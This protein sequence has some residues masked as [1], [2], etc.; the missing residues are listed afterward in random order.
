MAAEGF[1]RKL[2]AILS[3]DAVGYS[4]LM[5]EDEVATLRTL[6]TYKRVIAALIQQHRGRVVGSPGDNILAEFASVVDAVQCAV[7][8]QKEIQARNQELP[9]TRRMQF[10]IGINLGDV[11]ETEDSIYGDG[12]NI[13]ARLESLAE[14]GGICISKTAFDHIETKLP[15]GYEYLGGQTV[16]NIARPVPAYKVMMEPRVTLKAQAQAKPKE[17]ARRRSRF[18]A[19]VSILLLAV[20]AMVVWRFAFPLAGHKLEKAS[21][22]QMAFPL[23]DKP[24]IAVMPFLN[25]SGEQNQDFFCDGLSES[26]ITALSKMP[27]LFVIAQDSTFRYKGKGV[28]TKQVSEELGVQYVLE[29]SVQRAGDR[30]RVTAQLSDALTGQQLWSERYDRSVKDIFDLQDEI[31]MKILTE[32]R[33]KIFTGGETARVVTKETNNLQA[34][35]K[36]LEAAW[37]RN[38]N[39]KE[40]NAVSKRLLEEA[41]RLDPNY[42]SAHIGLSYTLAKEVWLGASESPQETLANAMKEARRAIELDNSSAEAQAAASNIFLLLRQHDK[43]IEVAQQAV[44]LNPN[45]F[46]AMY[47]LATALNFSFR[48]E[49]ALP[50]LRQVI[51]FNP[52]APAAYY[53][54]GV[55]CRETGKYEEGIAAVKKSLQIAPN[56]LFANIILAT[57]YSYAGREAEARAAAAEVMRIDPNFSLIKYAKGIPWK[58]GPQ[59]DR[60][61]KALRQAGLK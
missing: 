60:I 11:I 61:G 33:V 36:V 25:L 10:R 21:R 59:R 18:I 13:A 35:L 51:R 32:L 39:N 27:Q 29:G 52:F 2:T 58:E 54:F 43:A 46:T 56:S 30:V 28:K 4:R 24:S 7:A 1:K 19:L 3:T 48:S 37:Y 47:F 20:G 31:T 8:M 6:E 50:L 40:A 34:Y 12:V 17:G 26:L 14:P 9:E 57:L 5:G 42:V 49:E 55:A 38:Q 45:S 22:Q 41:V 15:L 16:K 44:R 23:P 53:Q